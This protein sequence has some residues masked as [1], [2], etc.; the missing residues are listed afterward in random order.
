MCDGC[1]YDVVFNGVRA[2][3]P[4]CRTAKECAEKIL[5]QVRSM[6]DPVVRLLNERPKLE[7]IR[8]RLGAGSARGRG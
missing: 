6:S 7:A 8:D 4:R 1:V 5:E 2:R 3:L